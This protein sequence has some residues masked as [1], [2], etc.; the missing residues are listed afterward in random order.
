MAVARRARWERG[1]WLSLGLQAL[2]K[3][4]PSGL[5]LDRLCV[6]AG[7][8]R[9]SFY[10][11][12]ADHAAFLDALCGHWRETFTHAL[13][14]RTQDG[15]AGQRLMDLNALAVGLDPAI[16]LGMRRLAC[17]NPAVRA[18]VASADAERIAYLERLHRDAG[19]DAGAAASVAKLE[20]AAFVGGQMLWPELSSAAAEKLG[21]LLGRM[22]DAYHGGENDAPTKP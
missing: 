9:G 3:E 19:L 12:F 16:E 2:A 7:R 22:V 10:H 6:E 17:T 13:I 4:G 21:V 20:Y 5:T 1:D 14:A 18:A 8:T 11:H 15:P